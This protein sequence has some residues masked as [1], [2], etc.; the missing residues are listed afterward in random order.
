MP[1]TFSPA[2]AGCETMSSVRKSTKRCTTAF[3]FEEMVRWKTKIFVVEKTEI[4][5]MSQA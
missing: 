4:S 2:K 1:F 3:Q 5:R